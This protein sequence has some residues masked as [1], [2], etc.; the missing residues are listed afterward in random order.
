MPV[1][2]V[3]VICRAFRPGNATALAT[4][5]VSSATS[6]TLLSSASVRPMEEPS[7]SFTPAI[8]YI[9]S[10]VGMKPPG[11]ALNIRPVPSSSSA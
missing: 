7:G 8:R 4:P 11:T 2:G 3:L 1:F 9:L 10:W 5:S 6:M